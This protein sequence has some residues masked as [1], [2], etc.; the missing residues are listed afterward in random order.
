MSNF[1]KDY[2]KNLSEEERTRRSKIASEVLKT[3]WERGCF[4]T[5]K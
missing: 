5:D 3:A 2:W 1:M 4:N